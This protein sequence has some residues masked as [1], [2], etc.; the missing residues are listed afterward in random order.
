[1]KQPCLLFKQVQKADDQWQTVLASTAVVD[2]TSLA[3]HRT[4]RNTHPTTREDLDNPPFK[5]REF[6][7]ARYCLVPYEGYCTEL[8]ELADMIRSKLAPQPAG[9]NRQSMSMAS[10]L[11]QFGAGIFSS[12]P[13]GSRNNLD[14]EDLG[15][16]YSP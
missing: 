1:M 2:A 3:S 11:T 4:N 16:G 9:E 13:V 15:E 6:I 12:S 5:A 10:L 8:H 7:A 14:D